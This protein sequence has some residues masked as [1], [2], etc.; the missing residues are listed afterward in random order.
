MKGE[1]TEASQAPACIAHAVFITYIGPYT[2]FLQMS[3]CGSMFSAAGYTDAACTQ[4]TAGSSLTGPT[5]SCTTAGATGGS[6]YVTCNSDSDSGPKLALIIGVAVGGAALLAG[7]A[8]GSYVYFC[9]SKGGAVAKVA[10]HP[11]SA[12]HGGD[13]VNM[14]QLGDGSARNAYA[15]SVRPN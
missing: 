11:G 5:G 6:Y 2:A 7:V 4:V 9:R 12:S 15:I 10:P 1:D 13:H 14:T 3:R 8:A